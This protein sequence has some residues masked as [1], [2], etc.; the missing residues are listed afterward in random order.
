MALG[1]MSR[2]P[3]GGQGQGKSAMNAAMQRQQQ[4]QMALQMQMQQVAKQQ[5][6][7]Q[8]LTGVGAGTAS[9]GPIA[10]LRAGLVAITP[11]PSLPPKREG[12]ASLSIREGG[13]RCT[14]RRA[15]AKGK[16]SAE[17]G[18]RDGYLHANP[19]TGAATLYDEDGLAVVSEFLD[20]QTQSVAT[21]EEQRDGQANL[22]N[23]SECVRYRLG[24]Y[25]LLC[26]APDA[27]TA[28]DLAA[29]FEASAGGAAAVGQPKKR[30]RV[31]LADDPE[32]VSKKR[33]RGTGANA[34][35]VEKI[36]EQSA[37]ALSMTGAAE[38][39]RVARGVVHEL[40]LASWDSLVGMTVHVGPKHGNTRRRRADIF[41]SL[42]PRKDLPDYY[43]IIA[44]PVD[45]N[46]IRSRIEIGWYE[47]G[48]DLTGDASTANK[49]PAMAE[50]NDETN[51]SAAS[52]AATESATAAASSA[53][54][55]AENACEWAFATW[56]NSAL[57]MILSLPSRK[58]VV[59]QALPRRFAELIC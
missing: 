25:L 2:R 18:G 16:K 33:L 47:P 34:L 39:H 45:L 48:I 57:K 24:D 38:C 36:I 41:M 31:K 14:Y 58:C 52:A 46:R 27:A 19:T 55:F 22:G 5:Q 17:A 30:R 10:S 49:T 53:A 23:L 11:L 21:L 42:P 4:Q 12:C 37:A 28:A 40:M 59:L 3:K 8:Q 1:T 13:I 15:P 56:R 35:I 43:R 29:G 50:P 26:E 9:K 6:Q 54:T 32:A 51:Q 44:K 20:M 7:Q